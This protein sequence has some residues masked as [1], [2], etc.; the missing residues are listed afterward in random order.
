MKTARKRIGSADGNLFSRGVGLASIVVLT[1]LLANAAIGA[2][3]S[4]ASSPRCTGGTFTL[5]NGLMDL[6]WTR[7]SHP[8]RLYTGPSIG[9]QVLQRCTDND[10]VCNTNDDCGNGQCQPTCDCNDDTTCEI[11]GPTQQSRCLTT[12]ATCTDNADCPP[13][14][15]CVYTFGPPLPLSAGGTPTCNMMHFETPLTGTVDTSTGVLA[16]QVNLR[17]RLHLGELIDRPCPRCGSPAQNPKPGEHFTCEGGQTPGAACAVEGVSPE[18]GGVSHDCAPTLGSNITGPG[19]VLRLGDLTTGTTT[20]T[21]QVPC[22][23]F[24]F[25]SNPLSGTGK[26]IDNNV[27]CSSN[28]D[29]M[30]C[31]G[32]PA[33]PCTGDGECAGKGACAEAPDQPISC[34][35]WCHC[36]FCDDDPALPCFDSSDCPQRQ[37]CRAG[38]GVGTA[39]NS[40]QQKPNDCSGDRFICGTQETETCAHTL[41]GH[42]SLQSYRA[43]SDDAPCPAGNAGTCVFDRHACFE[44]RMTRTGAP[45]P[46]GS[47]CSTT[48]AQC[49]TNGDCGDA[50][51]VPDSSA[52]ETVALACMPQSSSA[53]VNSA[54]GI[55]GPAAIS[56]GGFLK[57]C[58]E[59]DT[60]QEIIPV[61]ICGN[62]I[63]EYGEWCDDGDAAFAPG[64]YCDDFC[65][66]VPCGKPTNS[67]GRTPTASDA[68][69]ALRAAVGQ[70]SCDLR[71]CDADDSGAVMATDAL[72]ILNKAVGLEIALN[73]P[74]E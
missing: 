16:A 20:R 71:V 63:A 3:V 29:C 59:G 31:T 25:T 23:N 14:V 51:C 45:S 44:P 55:T 7:I 24:S 11:T 9:F 39:P 42:C 17:W 72:T 67:A 10:A 12:L 47:Y 19:V 22:K 62:G 60:C 2:V 49:T 41:I 48:L 33:T 8:S 32:D 35:Y 28:A 61:P 5:G 15:P 40:P 56:L 53:A 58:R 54:Y 46:L 4:E 1:A 21:A 6:G 30:R 13:N 38:G 64:D 70:V 34:G 50:A 65:K 66:L 27:E 74:V 18:F 52:L 43:C 73:C 36:G 37:T 26:C 68:Q 57:I 69:Y